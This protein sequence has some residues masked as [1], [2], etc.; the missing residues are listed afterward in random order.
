MCSAKTGD[1]Q[2][3]VFFLFSF[4]YQTFNIKPEVVENAHIDTKQAELIDKNIHRK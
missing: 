4:F 2:K 3:F 1:Q